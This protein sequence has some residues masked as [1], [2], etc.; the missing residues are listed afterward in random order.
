MAWS[1]AVFGIGLQRLER[2]DRVEVTGETEVFVGN[3]AL[4]ALAYLDPT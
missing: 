2:E 1:G 4:G 3:L